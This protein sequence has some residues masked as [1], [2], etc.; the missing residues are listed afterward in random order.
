MDSG[1]CA[2]PAVSSRLQDKTVTSTTVVVDGARDDDDAPWFGENYPPG[3]EVAGPFAL[4]A[5]VPGEVV[6]FVC[7]S[8]GPLRRFSQRFFFCCCLVSPS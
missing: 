3:Q 4:L 1:V 7:F 8:F 5:Q 6:N 2:R